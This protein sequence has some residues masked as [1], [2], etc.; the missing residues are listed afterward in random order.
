MSGEPAAKKE[1]CIP[2][3]DALLSMR[4]VKNGSGLWLSGKEGKSRDEKGY[5]DAGDAG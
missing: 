3:V 2:Y 1:S 4:H 5:Q